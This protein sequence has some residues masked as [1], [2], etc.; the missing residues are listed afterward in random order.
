M[1]RTGRGGPRDGQPG[2]AYQNRSDLNGSAVSMP[3]N[4]R[5]HGDR[6]TDDD[7]QRAT[8]GQ[9]PAAG[10]AARAASPVGPAPG[11][12]GGLA[13]PSRRPGEPLTAGL[14]FGPGAGEPEQ[15]FTEEDPDEF[16]RA[17]YMKFP[18]NEDLRELL[19]DRR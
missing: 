6:A 7:L 3:S 5:P 9:P 16:I 2:K 17:L 11:G 4:V 15:I 8:A 10:G 18:D 12:L 13:D 14:P 19:E 1:P